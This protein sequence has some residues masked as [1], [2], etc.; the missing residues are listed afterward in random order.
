MHICFAVYDKPFVFGEHFRPQF[1]ITLIRPI[2]FVES[3]PENGAS[4]L[5][6]VLLRS[7]FV[8]KALNI[9]YADR[10]IAFAVDHN[11]ITAHNIHRFFVCMPYDFVV[12]AL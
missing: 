12:C 3:A 4:V 10:I 1:S 11:G 9:H 5:I 2:V 7:H 6:E 8:I